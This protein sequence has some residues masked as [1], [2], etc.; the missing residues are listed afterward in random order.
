LGENIICGAFISCTSLSKI[1][2]KA[3]DLPTFFSG[4]TSLYLSLRM[5]NVVKPRSENRI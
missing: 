2:L 5:I 4:S 3:S 1:I